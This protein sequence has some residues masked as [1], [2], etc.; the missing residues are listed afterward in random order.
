MA[1]LCQSP[2]ISSPPTTLPVPSI[3]PTF[4][5]SSKIRPSSFRALQICAS[6]AMGRPDYET[7]L[8]NSA[9]TPESPEESKPDR[10]K[11]AFERAREYKKSLK[12]RQ[13]RKYPDGGS[14]GIVGGNDGFVSGLEDVGPKEVPEAVRVAME[15]AGEY[16]QT[17][18][19]ADNG[20]SNVDSENFPGGGKEEVAQAVRIA[21]EK[22]KEY[23]KNK[24]N[25]AGSISAL[26]S[27]KLTGSDGGKSSGLDDGSTES[28]IGKQEDPKISSID[29]VGLNFADKKRSRGLP[30]GL[31][32]VADPFTEGDLPEVEIIVGDASKFGSSA[33]SETKT[34][35]EEESPDLYKPKVSTWGVFPRPRDISKTFGGGRNIRPGEALETPQDRATKEARTKQLLASYERKIGLSMDPKL[36]AEC[37]EALEDG[38]L[39][40]DVGKLIEALPYYQLVM[41]K[42]AFQT[43]LHGLAALQWSICQDSLSRP[44]KARVM[45][46]KLRSHPNAQVSKKATQ[47]AFGFQVTIFSDFP[48]MEMMKV[49]RSTVSPRNTGYENYFEV[50][51][52]DKENYAS[53]RTESQEDALNQAI[54]YIIFLATP[55]L[56]VLLIAA[57]KRI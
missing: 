53:G 14:P 7:S 54:P 32:P 48:A 26:E 38:D 17:K 37:E 31:V 30:A 2:W 46:E 52:E 5:L 23:K 24:G 9:D 1:S 4:F 55:I 15:K 42:L 36:K 29:F 8:P 51:V 12:V 19:M 45:Y 27:L 35:S 39:L 11:L 10:V 3:K 21:I 49:T 41:D 22:A 18:G 33:A 57:S 43:E 44:E 16:K 20:R 56:L 25:I 47:F 13:N 34:S 28:K 50:F 6:S 40:M